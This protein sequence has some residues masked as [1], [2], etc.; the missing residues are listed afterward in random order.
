MVV[1]YLEEYLNFCHELLKRWGVFVEP[2]WIVVFCCIALFVS[3][4]GGVI[5]WTRRS[6]VRKRKNCVLILGAMNSGKTSFFYR[7]MTERCPKVVTSMAPNR[8]FARIEG[9]SVELVDFPG[10]QRLRAMLDPYLDQ[11]GVVIWFVNSASIASEVIMVSQYLYRVL[12]RTRGA[13]LVVACNMQDVLSAASCANI[14]KML[15]TE[16]DKLVLSR[17]GRLAI[18][19][20]EGREAVSEFST[21]FRFSQC[22]VYNFVPCS[23]TNNQV[24]RV[25]SQMRKLI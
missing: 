3:L 13:K 18:E 2:A 15:E 12:E 8:G 14:Q 22:G 5:G 11:A 16:I 24:D 1:S 6:A 10:H 23:V 17:P 25:V 4:L 20:E 9:K 19:G 7:M 21:P